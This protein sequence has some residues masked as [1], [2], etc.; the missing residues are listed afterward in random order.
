[1]KRTL[2]DNRVTLGGLTH[3]NDLPRLKEVDAKFIVD[4]NGT[5]DVSKCGELQ[6]LTVFLRGDNP[7]GD[8]DLACL[9]NLKNLQSLELSQTAFSEAGLARLEGLT[10][11]V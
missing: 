2:R 6:R 4:D 3:L 8:V 7:M 10:K 11:L 5:L 1:M 9:E